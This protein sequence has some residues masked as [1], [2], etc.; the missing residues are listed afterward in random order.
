MKI[1]CVGINAACNDNAS[2]IPEAVEVY[3]NE[4]ASFEDGLTKSNGSY[5]TEDESSNRSGV[6]SYMKNSKLLNSELN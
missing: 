1:S 5:T 4:S 6:H 3:M 2:N